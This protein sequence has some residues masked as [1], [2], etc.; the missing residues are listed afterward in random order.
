MSSIRLAV[1]LLA[2]SSA[3]AEARGVSCP[4]AIDRKPLS[5]VTVFDGRPAEN[6]SLV[7]NKARSKRGSRIATWHVAGIFRA[8]RTVF[9]NCEYG[10]TKRIFLPV[11]GARL[12]TY[13]ER[14]KVKSMS[15][16]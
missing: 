2:A 12:C 5:F 14:G 11:K 13:A 9:L 4:A 15:C 8:G 10:K 3:A 6:A 7:P 1:L 16:R